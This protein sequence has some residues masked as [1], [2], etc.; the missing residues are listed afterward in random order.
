[1][2]RTTKPAPPPPRMGRPI[3]LPGVLGELARIVGGTKA[4]AELLGVQPRTIQRWGAGRVV[5]ESARRLLARVAAEHNLPVSAQK[6]LSE[7][8][9][10]A[11]ST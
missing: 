11:A 3:E 4:L 1:M 8:N 2:P 6:A 7:L 5:P 10:G 9:A